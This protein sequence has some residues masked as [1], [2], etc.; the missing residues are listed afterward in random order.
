MKTRQLFALAAAALLLATATPAQ[1]QSY[2]LTSPIYELAV[3]NGFLAS[4]QLMPLKTD[5]QRADLHGNVV[6]VMETRKWGELSGYGITTT[7]ITATF[8]EQ[9]NLLKTVEPRT[10]FSS[11]K[12]ADAVVE[13]EYENGRLKKYIEQ[14][15]AEIN[16]RLVPERHVHTLYYNEQQKPVKEIYQAYAY[17]NGKWS[18]FAHSD[19]PAWTFTWDAQ[20]RLTDGIITNSYHAKFNEQGLVT[21]VRIGKLPPAK[22][23]W[24]AQ[25]RCIGESSY[26]IDGM[27]EEV[28]TE[29]DRTISYNDKGSIVKMVYTSYTCNSKWKRLK[30]V[31]TE[32]F[33]AKYTYDA[34][35]NWTKAT[36]T[37]GTGKRAKAYVTI[38]RA[39]T[40]GE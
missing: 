18:E 38:T 25:G 30:K 39:I 15:E 23:R 13:Y 40:Y 6:K 1:A 19:E 21:E 36:V 24:D 17:E 33:T 2:G 5:L 9:G 16:S 11:K 34:Q 26:M 29:T 22:F 31:H 3:D 8:N 10:S 12:M 14:Y 35:G 28:Y 27:D 7:T 32:T 20:G 37:S 4:W